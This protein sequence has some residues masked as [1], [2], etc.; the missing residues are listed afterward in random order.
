MHI[1]VGSTKRLAAAAT[2]FAGTMAASE[3][4]Q[5]AER[6]DTM[7]V[8]QVRSGMRGHARTVF[9]GQAVEQFE[10]EVVDVIHHFLPKQDAVLFRSTDPRLQHSGIV[11]GMSGSPIFIE[12]KLVGAL[13]Y[14][15]PFNKDPLGGLTPIANMFETR[16]L[17]YRP[18]VLPY[19]RRTGAPTQAHAEP[20]W[21]QALLGLGTSPLPARANLVPREGLVPLDVPLS[22]AGFGPK[23][24]D[25]LSSSLGLSAAQGGGSAPSGTALAPWTFGSSV[26]VV[27]I[28]G[29]NAAAGNGTVT[30]VN[31][32]GDRLL[33]FG[34][35]MMELGPSNLPFGHAHVHTILSSV[36]RSVKLASP[37]SI[38]GVMYQ[39]RQPAIALR[40]DK[41]APMIDV[42]TALSSP[43]PALGTRRY[44]NRVAVSPQLTPSLVASILAQAVEEG[45]GDKTE[46]MVH[47]AQDIAIATSKGPRSL[48]FEDDAFLAEGLDGPLLARTRGILALGAM[49]ENDFEVPTVLSVN[50]Q[51]SLQY[52]AHVESIA[53]VRVPQDEVHAGDLVQLEVG[54]EPYE[55]KLRVEVL[56]VRIPEQA[57][58]EEIVIELTGGTGA[59]HYAAIPDSLDALLSN[60]EQRYPA[61]SLVVSLYRAPE[62]L[63]TRKGLLQP[64][65]DSV[66]E[67]LQDVGSTRSS[68]RFKQLARRVLPMR[69][70]IS[71]SHELKLDVLR[72]KSL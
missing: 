52:G 27:L 55:G 34:H 28:E 71:G 70:I 69:T 21:A 29:D 4:A 42:V 64:M 30:W 15:W 33:A 16:D 37:L 31:E 13:A 10:I 24:A 2:A 32:A 36:Q 53:F 61:R 56:P 35:P 39:D 54:L 44:V 7:P 26:S 12:G 49:F 23:S 19:G 41:R 20:S 46:I 48:H 8:S 45:G 72:K 60:L 5:A 9:S 66:L 43:E 18:D 14:G 1:A 58:G 47:V 50:N 62:G 40:T 51:V 22:L 3:P 63:S 11:G 25:F 17:P 57:G 6:V 59:T 38:D 68:V 67:T 65:P